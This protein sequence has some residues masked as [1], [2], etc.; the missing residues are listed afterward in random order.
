MPLHHPRVETM[1]FPDQPA[2]QTGREDNI[3]RERRK[4]AGGGFGLRSRR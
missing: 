3:R 2:L 1:F 4:D